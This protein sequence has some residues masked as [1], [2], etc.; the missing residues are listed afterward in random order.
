MASKTF[1]R[2]G[3]L[4]LYKPPGMTSSQ[5]V[6]KLKRVLN[7]GRKT[8][9]GHGGTLDPSA[10]GVLPIG[11]GSCTRL[12]QV[13]LEYTPEATWN[14]KTDQNHHSISI[15]PKCMF[16]ILTLEKHRPPMMQ[17]GTSSDWIR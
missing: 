5:C 7:L 13:C 8:K 9:I 10:V 11:I 4:N 17:M 15:N 2:C 12:F 6:Q 16:L 1:G 14:A 3:F